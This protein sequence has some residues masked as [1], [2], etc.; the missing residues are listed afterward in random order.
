MQ[1]MHV[2]MCREFYFLGH[3]IRT[4]LYSYIFSECVVYVLSHIP[5]F[6]YFDLWNAPKFYS[7]LFKG[8]VSLDP[9]PSLNHACTYIGIPSGALN[10][11]F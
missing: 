11:C 9:K 10:F 8:I 7:T 1:I 2:I 5:H 6:S 3:V 4:V